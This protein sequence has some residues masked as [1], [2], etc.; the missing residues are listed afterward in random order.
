MRT[1]TSAVTS[2]A[3]L[4]VTAPGYLVEISFATPLRYSTRGTLTWDSK[5]WTAYDVRVSGIAWD[6]ASSGLT[7]SL[8]IG[9]ADLAIGQSVLSEGVAGRAI[10]VWAIYGDSPAASDPVLVFD[11]IGDG[12]TIPEVGA[13]TIDLQQSGGTTQFCPRTYL[14]P[15][16]GFSFLPTPGQIVVW[17]GETVR[18]DAEG[19]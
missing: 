12:A 16:A 17:D 15:E 2:A 4:T 8:A 14:T 1:L 19:I 18:L 13:V 3:A 6:G 7:G 10:K 11:G 5:T 9:N